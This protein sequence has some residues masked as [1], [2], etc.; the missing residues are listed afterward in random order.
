VT[1]TVRKQRA[2]D[3]DAQLHLPIGPVFLLSILDPGIV[4]HTF[5]ICFPL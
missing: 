1:T 5:R 3:A 4:L 2:I